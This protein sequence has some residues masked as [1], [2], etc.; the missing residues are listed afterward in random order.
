MKTYGSL[1]GGEWL[2]SRPGHFIPGTH[3]IG[4]WVGSIAGPEAVA[5]RKIPS[6]CRESKPGRPVHSLV[7]I[8][9]DLCRLQF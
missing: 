7:A 6:P 5:K 4:G 9:A 2:T 3:Y 8:P 1:D